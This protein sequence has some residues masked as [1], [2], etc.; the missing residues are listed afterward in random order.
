MEFKEQRL[1]FRLRS[2]LDETRK[3]RDAL[4]AQLRDL[5]WLDDRWENPDNKMPRSI[6]Q[7]IVRL[8]KQMR[9]A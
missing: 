5:I 4:L 9:Q 2:R 1:L 7:G 3:E 8:I 6:Y